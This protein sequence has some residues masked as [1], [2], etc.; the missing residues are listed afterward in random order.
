[1]ESVLVLDKD[2]IT[3]YGERRPLTEFPRGAIACL[4]VLAEHAGQ[5]VA[6]KEIIKEAGLEIDS[7]NLKSTVSRLRDI[8]RPL[9]AAAAKRDKRQCREGQGSGFFRGDGAPEHPQGLS[10]L[11]LDSRLVRVVPPRPKWMRSRL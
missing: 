5:P 2:C 11:E 1:S 4:W 7:F 6:R 9:S 3:F 10:C 8:L